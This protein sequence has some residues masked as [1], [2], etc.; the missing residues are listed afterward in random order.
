M[1]THGSPGAEEWKGKTMETAEKRCAFIASQTA[2]AM[3]EIEGMKAV[4]QYRE[5]QG[6]SQ[7]YGEEDFFA[8]PDKYVIGHNAVIEYLRDVS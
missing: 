4:N 8:I 7:A 2:C 6:Y 1:L 5:M 3:A